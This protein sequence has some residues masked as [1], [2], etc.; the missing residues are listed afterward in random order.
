MMMLEVLHPILNSSH[1]IYFSPSELGEEDF[2]FRHEP[3][4]RLPVATHPSLGQTAEKPAYAVALACLLL[5][6]AV[7]NVATAILVVALLIPGHLGLSD[8]LQALCKLLPTDR[9]IYTT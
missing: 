8:L 1:H 9:L 4:S 3:L 5:V 7:L 2:I 6:W